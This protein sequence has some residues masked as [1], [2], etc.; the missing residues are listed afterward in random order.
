VSGPECSVNISLSSI[1]N[2][3]GGSGHKMRGEYTTRKPDLKGKE[4]NDIKLLSLDLVCFQTD[5]EELKYYVMKNRR[6]SFY[7]FQCS[8]IIDS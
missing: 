6:L 1:Y 4:I 2:I 3:I 8:F 5:L 7:I